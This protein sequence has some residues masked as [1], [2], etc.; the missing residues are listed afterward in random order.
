MRDIYIKEFNKK[1]I[2]KINNLYVVKEY[3]G[4]ITEADIT[5]MHELMGNAMLKALYDAP[6]TVLYFY[7]FFFIHS[8]NKSVFERKTHNSG[9][10]TKFQIFQQENP[11]EAAKMIKIGEKRLTQRRSLFRRHQRI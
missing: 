5:K 2:D 10:K 9:I 3:G 1:F 4:E 8:S 7:P 6:P 11:E